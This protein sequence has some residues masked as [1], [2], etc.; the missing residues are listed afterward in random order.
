MIDPFFKRKNA[1]E[2]KRRG[3]KLGELRISNYNP[4]TRLVNMSKIVPDKV[5]FPYDRS[6]EV[7]ASP[8]S[9]PQHA[10]VILSN[11]KS[12]ENQKYRC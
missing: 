7:P 9:P 2:P 3:V 4:R 11:I 10:Q 1:H 5:H 6:H 8:N 12:Y